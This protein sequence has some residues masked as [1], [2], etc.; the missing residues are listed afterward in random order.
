MS[1]SWRLLLVGCLLAGPAA[2]QRGQSA[3][4][5]RKTDLIRLLTS[6]GVTKRDIAARVRRNCLSFEPSARDRADLQSSG[7]DSAIFNAIAECAL[8]AGTLRIAAPRGVRAVAGSEVTIEARVLRY[9]VP[10]PGV[11]LLLLGTRAIP[12]GP[13]QDP[14][15]TTDASGTARFRLPAGLRPGTYRLTVIAASGLRL[16]AAV[17]L[18]TLAAP[19]WGAVVAPAELVQR[20][21][22]RAGSAL[23]VSVTGAGQMPA[24]GV[25]LELAGITAE[26]VGVA[27]ATTDA[28]G[29]ALFTIP[30]G[31]VRRSGTVGVFASGQRLGSFTVRLETVTLSADRTRFIG[32]TE[33]RGTVRTAL[34]APLAFEV[35]DT[36]G[37]PVGGYAVTLEATNGGIAPGI[38]TT[39]SNGVVRATL[40]LGERAGPVVVT[41]TAGTV[42]RQATLAALPG[43]PQQLVVE[44]G[45]TP[46]TGTLSLATRDSVTLRVVARDAYG[47]DARL[48]GLAVAVDGG[49][50]RLQRPPGAA[51]PGSV[52]IAPR[53]SGSAALA[54]H[55]S[56]LTTTL[57]V[58]VTLPAIVTGAWGFGARAGGA[59]FSYG[60]PQLSAIDGRPGFRAEILVGRAVRPGLRL[61]A[62]LG[63]GMLGAEMGS[64]NLA[65]GLFQGLVR[66]EYA[67]LPNA[68]VHPVIALGGG[69]YRI[70]STDTRNAVYHT[71]VLWLFGFGAD[72]P[73]SPRL[74]GELRLERQQ[75][76]E[77]NSTHA[78]GAVGA[79]TVFEVGVRITR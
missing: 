8:P 3:Q 1:V 76:I 13:E 38:G 63:L 59:A 14:G 27:P 78:N 40:T 62:G 52:V 64:A 15:A 25:A 61:E 32:G 69:M 12:G 55:G 53:K 50:I 31:A 23:R 34:R 19:E 7:A 29:M 66:G 45:G 30:P 44:R 22:S 9:D 51:G 28:Q 10:Q 26:L 71:S 4:P 24:R 70:K 6:G 49:A 48:T 58:E 75:L 17:A 2:A 43:P 20:S 35:R 16:R 65:V 72:Y 36:A 5:L 57:P 37:A 46:L 41:A 33:Q 54:I 39:D 56:G 67:L 60:F 79:L 42:R 47:N 68:T 21:G 77:A 11:S 73:L 74:T 18:T